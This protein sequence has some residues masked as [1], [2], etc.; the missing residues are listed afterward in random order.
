MG[1]TVEHVQIPKLAFSDKYQKIN[2]VFL[3][4]HITQIVYTISGKEHSFDMKQGL[5]D[6]SMRFDIFKLVLGEEPITDE[7]EKTN[8]EDDDDNK[9]DNEFQVDD[10]NKVDNNDA[11]NDN[12]DD[13]DNKMNDDNKSDD[14]T[15]VEE[16]SEEPKYTKMVKKSRTFTE[17]S[18]KIDVKIPVGKIANAL[19]TSIGSVASGGS[20]TPLLIPQLKDAV[21]NASW[22]DNESNEDIVEHFFDGNTYIFVEMKRNITQKSK[23][24]LGVFG[25]NQIEIKAKTSY[26]YVEAGNESAKKELQQLQRRQAQDAFKYI[27]NKKGWS[28]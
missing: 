1:D 5:K 21:I 19:V 12:D 26:F 13:D 15:K 11:D 3:G 16:P 22:S 6:G 18:K 27:T 23:K 10:D 2:D 14:D 25:K 9:L 28:G 24:T 7:E 4:R 17:T 20:L 8:I